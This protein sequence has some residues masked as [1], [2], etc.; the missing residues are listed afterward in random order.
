MAL[1]L[2]V[3]L[4][5][6][7][8][9]TSARWDAVD[10]LFKA[11]PAMV[12]YRGRFLESAMRRERVTKSE[13]LAAIRSAHMSSSDK[14]ESVVLETAGEFSVVRKPDGSAPEAHSK[15]AAHSFD[16]LASMSPSDSR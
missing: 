7:V 16:T 10:N 3:G 5:F 12:F 1:A 4:Q 6:L 15:A 2:L 9:W 8:A 13:I 14:V 11:E